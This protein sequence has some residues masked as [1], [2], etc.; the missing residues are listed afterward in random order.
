MDTFNRTPIL[1]AT[2][3]GLCVLIFISVNAAETTTGLMARH[4]V[5]ENPGE[6]TSACSAPRSC[7]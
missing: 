5:F 2:L 6:I 7:I 3:I 4:L 1:T